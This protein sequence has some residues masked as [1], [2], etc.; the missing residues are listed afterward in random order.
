MHPEDP[1][2]LEVEKAYEQFIKEYISVPVEHAKAEEKLTRS[3]KST[4]SRKEKAV[5]ARRRNMVKQ[6]KRKN[7]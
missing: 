1:K 4:L 5:R 6:S 2:D 3:E 7:R